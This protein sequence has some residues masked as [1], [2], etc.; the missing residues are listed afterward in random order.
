MLEAG[1]RACPPYILGVDTTVLTVNVEIA[2]TH[3]YRTPMAFELNCRISRQARALMGKGGMGQQALDAMREHGAV[4]FST[5]G[6]GASILA[7]GVRQIVEMVDPALFLSELEVERFGPVV[8]ALDS[9]TN[10]LPGRFTGWQT[11]TLA[12]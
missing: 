8:V 11:Y 9:Q 1:L 2:S 4:Y 5:V 3:Y 12:W 6:A 10:H 7:H